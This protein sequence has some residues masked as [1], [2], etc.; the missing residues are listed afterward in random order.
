MNSKERNWIN[1]ILIL[2]AM[3]N[4]IGD[5]G[6]IGLWYASSDSQESLRGSYIANVAGAENAL[7]AGTLVLAIVAFAYIS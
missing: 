3:V 1:L 5:I 6:N 7:I 2:L 4:I